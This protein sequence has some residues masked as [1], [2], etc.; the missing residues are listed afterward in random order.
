MH[1]LEISAI[2]RVFNAEVVVENVSLQV[3][4]GEIVSIVGPSGCGKTTLLRIAAGLLTPTSGTVLLHAGRIGFVFQDSALLPWQ[5]VHENAALLAS[6]ADKEFV[7]T[8][9]ERTGLSGH[10]HKWPHEL[11]GGMKMR[12]S[13]VR[14][15]AMRPSVVLADEPFGALDQ[16]TR[17]HLQDEL[18]FLH[19]LHAFTILLVTHAIDEAVYLS[20]RVVTMSAAPGRFIRSTQVAFERPRNPDLRYSAEFAALCGRV[21]DSLRRTSP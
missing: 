1:M 4:E 20:D 14:T 15:L 17:Q 7:E 19:S 5:N 9:L 2:S 10:R 12:L 6:D 11:S 13:L 3:A 21:A 18:L 8:L 16:M